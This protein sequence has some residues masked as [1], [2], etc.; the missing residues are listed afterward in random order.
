MIWNLENE[1]LRVVI[2]YF[3]QLVLVL[4]SICLAIHVCIAI[5]D[6]TVVF[7]VISHALDLSD[8]FLSVY[9]IK[10]SLTQLMLVRKNFT[11]K[12][13]VQLSVVDQEWQL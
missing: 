11:I 9:A 6:L 3:K 1:E 8:S 7:Q 10:F 13:V 5:D 2:N 4:V 12:Q